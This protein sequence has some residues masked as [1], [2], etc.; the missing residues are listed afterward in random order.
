M[1]CKLLLRAELV[2]FY[3]TLLLFA[4]TGEASAYLFVLSFIA[5]TA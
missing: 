2:E 1:N 5:K 4:S 3:C